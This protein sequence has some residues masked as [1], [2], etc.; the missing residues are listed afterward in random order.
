MEAVLKRTH[1]DKAIWGVVLLLSLFSLLI[2]YSAT[3]SLAFKMRQGHTEYYLIKQAIIFL[4]GFFIIWI[5]HRAHYTVYN[6]WA[7]VLYII[8]IPLLLVT[9]TAG[10][11]LN[12]G[13][14]WLPIPGTGLTF[15]P[16]D[17]A[18]LA[19]FMFLARQL[20]LYQSQIH[21]RKIVFTKIFL[22]AIITVIL[23][24]P[25]NLS[26]ALMLFGTCL[27]LFFIGRVRIL[28][29]LQ[30]IAMGIFGFA[31]L[32]GIM[33]LT[34]TGRTK[35]WESR[36]KA[37]FGGS[38]VSSAKDDEHHFQKEQAQIAIANG[39]IIGVGAGK[40]MQKNIVPHPYS[41]MVF[42]IIIEEYGLMG[43]SFLILLYLF[44]LYR[45]I[46]LFRRCPYAFGAFLS[47]GLSFTLVIQAFLNMGVGVGLFP[48]T[49]LTLPLISMGGTSVW[50]T[51]LAIGIILSVSK[52]VDEVENK[53]KSVEAVNNQ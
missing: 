48:V 11:K 1:G 47:L 16:S 44:F 27:I 23:I 14:R 5:T 22:P 28:H 7:V 39:G 2:I 30:L 49:G 37:Y 21:D 33:K 40:S 53:N 15:Q 10:A 34:G 20:S 26:T 9:L 19:L 51:S 32:F 18:K 13:A 35:T 8:S 24:L 29:L 52:Y 43:A 12:G 42:P 3:D 6:K 46:L 45:S 25:A 36:V 50:F 4:V 31:L 38:T 17:F 41:D